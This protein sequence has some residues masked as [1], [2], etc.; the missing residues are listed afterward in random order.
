MLIDSG[1]L[2]LISRV[3]SATCQIQEFSYENSKVSGSP[4]GY[5]LGLYLNGKSIIQPYLPLNE[6]DYILNKS[7]CSFIV[8]TSNLIITKLENISYDVFID[9]DEMTVLC[10]E[11]SLAPCLVLSNADRLFVQFLINNVETFGM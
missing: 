6:V 7:I 10:K 2:P 3:D 11:E 5:P 8:G 4:M 1:P 9:L